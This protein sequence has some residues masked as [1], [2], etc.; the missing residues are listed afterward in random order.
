[1]PFSFFLGEVC[2]R[3]LEHNGTWTA[4][5]SL[6]TVVQE[7]TKLIDEPSTDGIQHTGQY[8]LFIAF[9]CIHFNLFLQKRLIYGILIK[10]NINERQQRYLTIIVHHV[11][12]LNIL[13]FLMTIKINQNSSISSCLSRSCSVII[14]A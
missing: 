2:L 13:S 3:L 12:K 14:F 1:M 5:T 10:T 6:R 8:D 11:I 4:A 7:V 9:L